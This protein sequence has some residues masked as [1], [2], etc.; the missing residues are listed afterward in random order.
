MRPIP[1]LLFAGAFVLSLTA[2][3]GDD[4][5]TAGAS[6]G[7]VA[8]DPLPAPVGAPGAG[9]TGMPDEPGPNAIRAPGEAGEAAGVALDEFGNPLP[10]E[11]LPVEG[12]P[13]DADAVAADGIPVDPAL[14]ASMPD[15]GAVAM[16]ATGD[17]PGPQEAVA[18]VR[19]YYDAI[20]AG[21]FGRAYALWSDG[22]RA[23]GQSPQQFADGFAQ[24]AGMA[25]EVMAPGRVDA[26]AG[27][28]RIEVPV[29]LTATRRDGSERRYVGAYVLQRAAVDGA[30]PEQRAWRIASADLREVQP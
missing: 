27:S 2:C 24:T 3:T 16:P 4:R 19:A 29:A 25:V 11:G 5:P 21:A 17:G 12:V 1:S 20:S 9:V 10:A 8:N 22:G 15:G 18:L 13:A 26:A 6:S 23:S 14:T 30:S 7:G 28:H